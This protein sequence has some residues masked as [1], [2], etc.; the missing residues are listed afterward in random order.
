MN[1]QTEIY[2]WIDRQTDGQIER[3]MEGQIG[4]QKTRWMD[5]ESDALM[6]RQRRQTDVHFNEQSDRQAGKLKQ[7]IFLQSE[8]T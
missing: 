6:D 4:R 2:E 8:A 1:R 5:I 3:W 7:P